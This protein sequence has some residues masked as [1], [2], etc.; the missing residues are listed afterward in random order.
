MLFI[1]ILRSL[2]KKH[3]QYIQNLLQKFSQRMFIF[4][5]LH[6]CMQM[7]RKKS[8][9][10]HTKTIWVAVYEEGLGIAAVLIQ[11]LSATCSYLS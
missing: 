1:I 10:T 4:V 8:D 11:L 2:G 5:C 9:V 3:Q 7:Y 6:I